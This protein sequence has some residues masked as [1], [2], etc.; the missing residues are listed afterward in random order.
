MSKVIEYPI[1]RCEISSFQQLAVRAWSSQRI[2]AVTLPR[3][4]QVASA[5]P[6]SRGLSVLAIR[7]TNFTI[8]NAELLAGPSTFF[9]ARDSFLPVEDTY[10]LVGRLLGSLGSRSSE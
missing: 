7:L 3:P 1:L 6:R 10:R 2:L 4:P 9:P 8:K 5:F